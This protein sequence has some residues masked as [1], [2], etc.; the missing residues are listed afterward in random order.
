MRSCKTPSNDQI[1]KIIGCISSIIVDAPSEMGVFSP[2]LLL[3]IKLAHAFEK[4]NYFW[5]E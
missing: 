4:R 5:K 1:H 2:N 3:E